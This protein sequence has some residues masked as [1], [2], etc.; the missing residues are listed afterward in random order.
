MEPLE[1][2]T[3]KEQKLRGYDPLISRG[4]VKIL[5]FHIDRE[6]NLT[7]IVC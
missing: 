3:T 4:L 5:R 2:E 1:G 6:T 7:D